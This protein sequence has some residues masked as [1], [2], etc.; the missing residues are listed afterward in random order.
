MVKCTYFYTLFEAQNDMAMGKTSPHDL[1]DSFTLVLVPKMS[2][3]LISLTPIFRKCF[4]RLVLRHIKTELAPHLTGPVQ[5]P[6]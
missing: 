6:C 2:P 3:G 5:F 4:D 1:T